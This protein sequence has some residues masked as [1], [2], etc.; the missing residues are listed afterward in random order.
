MKMISSERK[1]TRRKMVGVFI[2]KLTDQVYLTLYLLVLPV[3][4]EAG[5]HE[6][7]IWDVHCA[8]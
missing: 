1:K 4:Y 5:S 8:A 2:Y 7:G 3:L 6:H